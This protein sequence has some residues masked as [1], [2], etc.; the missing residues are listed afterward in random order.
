MNGVPA[1]WL[2]AGATIHEVI[3]Q[4]ACVGSWGAM[5]SQ[6]WPTQSQQHAHQQTVGGSPNR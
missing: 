2:R 1:G 5:I 4:R 3:P 6:R